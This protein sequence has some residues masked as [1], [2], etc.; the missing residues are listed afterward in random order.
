MPKGTLRGMMG[1]QWWLDTISQVRREEN[2]QIT[3]KMTTFIEK[4]IDAMLERVE[5]GDEVI[6][7]KDGTRYRT[8]V[9]LRDLAI[10]VGVLTD[11]RNLLRGQATSRSESLGQEETLRALGEKFEQFAKK[12]KIKEPEVIDVQPIENKDG[13]DNV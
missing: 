10:P 1:E 2:D 6:N 9:R 8:P 4:S 13:L 12:L 5:N 7:L 3:A 11:K